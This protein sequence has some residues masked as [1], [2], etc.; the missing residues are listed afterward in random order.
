VTSSNGVLLANLQPGRTVDFTP[1]AAGPAAPTT[2]TGCLESS[3][4]KYLLTDEVSLVRFEVM[5]SGV[6]KEAGHRVKI[7]GTVTPV[8]DSM[9]QVQ[10]TGVTQLSKK[11]SKGGKAAAA[12][13][14][15]VGAPGAGAAGAAGAGGAAAGGIGAAIAAHA[16]I[17][18]VVV[19]GAATV[20]AVA[21]VKTQEDSPEISPSGR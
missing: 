14:A 16:V 7:D 3:G 21:I 6:A 11:C 12:A 1:E 20:A 9:S 15:G 17:A 18:G 2:I 10:S 5:G 19:A 4:G 13:A 8:T